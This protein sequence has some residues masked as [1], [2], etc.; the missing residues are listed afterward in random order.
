[1]TD[2]NKKIIKLT[3]A[4]TWLALILSFSFKDAI[5]AS[6]QTC[7]VE[8]PS[9]KKLVATP[10]AWKNKLTIGAIVGG[11]AV[12]AL[13]PCEFAILIFLMGTLLLN[14]ERKKALHSGIA[15]CLAIYLSYLAMGLGLLKIIQ[16]L[17]ISLTTI[18]VIGVLSIIFGLLHLK[19]YINYGAGGFI[20]EVPRSWRPK[21]KEMVSRVTNPTGA[22]LIGLI[23]SIFLL[24]CTSG[25][26]VAILTLLGVK[27]ISGLKAIAYLLLYNLIFIIPMAVMVWLMYA[28]LK[29]TEAGEWRKGKIKLLHLIAGIIMILLG[30]AIIMGWI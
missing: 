19:D 16:G 15:F 4:I 17:H 26:Y 9:C 11:A 24:P 28:G 13:N 29:A 18:K 12:D 20:M 27:S 21:M 3:I 1:M 2:F 10:T 22:F 23:I 7:S 8:T 14:G 5:V 6:D 25:P 30:I